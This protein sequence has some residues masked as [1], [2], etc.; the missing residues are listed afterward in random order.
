MGITDITWEEFETFDKVETPDNLYIR[1]K[2]GTYYTIFELGIASVR[3]VFDISLADFNEYITGNHSAHDLLFKA[4][5][6]AWPPT[7]EEKNRIS[8][9]RAMDRPIILISNP[10]NL[11]LFTREELEKLI[12][13]AEQ[14][15][16]EWKGKLPDDYVSPLE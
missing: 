12:P 9:E 4:Q 7:E 1:E 8:K 5:N 16:I 10:R 11:T 3:R 15:W 14:K 13:I 2:N 6:D